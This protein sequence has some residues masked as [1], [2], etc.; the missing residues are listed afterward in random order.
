MAV[1][2]V[3]FD[4]AASLPV[5]GCKKVQVSSD[6]ESSYFH[7]SECGAEWLTWGVSD[8]GCSSSEMHD[9]MHTGPNGQCYQKP[10]DTSKWHLASCSCA[11][12]APAPSATEWMIGLK[13][14][15]SCDTICDMRDAVCV[16]DELD[17]LTSDDAML[18][19]FAAAGVTCKNNHQRIIRNCDNKI[20]NRCQEWGAPFINSASW[21]NG[22]YGVKACQ[23]GSKIS[24][25]GQDPV[26]HNHL[27]LCPCAPHSVATSS[28]FA[29]DMSVPKTDTQARSSYF[30][31]GAPEYMY[32]TVFVVTSAL[33]VVYRHH[34]GFTSRATE[35]RPDYN[36][37]YGTSTAASLTKSL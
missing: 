30:G 6:G 3:D 10:G 22:P 4:Y 36:T 14:R 12:P 24:P 7:I 1:G 9:A 11:A 15:G 32:A 34:A 20:P 23:G 8:R 19:K 33:I 21:R 16:Q 5:D 35:T 26:D 37:K 31:Y 29:W 2:P 28:K 17:A 25:C 18:E 27:R 13:H